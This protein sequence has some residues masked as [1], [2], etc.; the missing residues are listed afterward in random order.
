MRHGSRPRARL[1]VALVA[2][3]AGGGVV[4]PGTAASAADVAC[5]PGTTTYVPDPPPALAR[6]ASEA[7]WRTATGAGVVVAVVD[8]GV[9]PGNTHLADALLPGVDLVGAGG[10]PTGLSDTDGHGTAV[11]GQIAARA[12]PGSGVVGLAPDA[13]VLP[14]RVFL[15]DDEQSVRD[16]NG[17]RA[18]R[19]AA[20]I[21]YAAEHGARVVNVSMST[22]EDSPEL[23]SAVQDATRAGVLVVASVG[24]R[25]TSGGAADGPRYPAGYPEVLAVTAVDDADQVTDGSVRGAHVDVAAPGT[26]V[27]TT[28]H[29]AGDCL[30]AGDQASTSFATAY[31][32]AAAALL[33]ERYPDE[34]PDQWRYRLEVTAA[35]VR[36]GERDD[37]VGWGIVRPDQALA[38]VDDGS[39]AGPV[40]PV[41]ARPTAA[42]DAAEHVVVEVR[43]DPLATTRGVGAWWTWGGL[44]AV[45][46]AVL[47]ARLGG[48]R[49]RQ[50]RAP[51]S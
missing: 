32:S 38:F 29:A 27:L 45:L 13:R 18:D 16:G 9:D 8:S 37:L 5:T 48:T 43:A 23:R 49:R 10:D 47:T 44:T 14:V 7:A 41:H 26:N 4:V 33:A 51:S 36:P 21:R 25:A 39:A 34:T 20:G 35:R 46:L 28:Y 42:T 3:V 50:A 24:S 2:L 19:V 11:A 17:P 15:A 6:L 1:V 40:S 30:L 31:V 12:V 22:T